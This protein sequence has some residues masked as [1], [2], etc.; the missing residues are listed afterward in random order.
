MIVRSSYINK[1]IRDIKIYKITYRIKRM[2]NI[3]S[4]LNYSDVKLD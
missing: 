3:V 1:I 4:S 2:Y